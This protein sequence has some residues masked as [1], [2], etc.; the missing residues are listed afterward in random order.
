M[1]PKIPT[2]NS[3]QIKANT[4]KMPKEIISLKRGLF[5]DRMTRLMK[6]AVPKSKTAAMIK[7][8]EDQFQPSTKRFAKKATDINNAGKAKIIVVFWFVEIIFLFLI[9]KSTL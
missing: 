1:L 7:S 6:K 3:I 8:E 9:F 4:S 2:A 5:S